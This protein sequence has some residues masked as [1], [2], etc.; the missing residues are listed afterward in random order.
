MVVVLLAAL[1]AS[2]I[3]A[4]THGDGINGRGRGEQKVWV[5]GQSWF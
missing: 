3:Y 4:E 1:V 5:G 2:P